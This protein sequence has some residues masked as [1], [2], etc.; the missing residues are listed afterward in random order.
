MRL[1][2][3]SGDVGQTR[4][5]H[6]TERSLWLR[7]KNV[8]CAQEGR[9]VSTGLPDRRGASPREEPRTERCLGEHCDTRSRACVRVQGRTQDHSQVF[10]W[11]WGRPAL[12]R[13]L[14]STHSCLVAPGATAAHHFACWRSQDRAPHHRLQRHPW[15]APQSVATENQSLSPKSSHKPQTRDFQERKGTVC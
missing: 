2:Q 12:R 15:R 4:K 7:R 3:L 9:E 10:S 5:A 14:L 11:S 13:P 1:G 6:V 8:V